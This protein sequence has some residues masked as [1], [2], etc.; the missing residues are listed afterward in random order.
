MMAGS[1][2]SFTHWSLEKVI[3]KI[4]QSNEQ[5]KINMFKADGHKESLIFAFF[6][7]FNLSVRQLSGVS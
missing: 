7:S 3:P 6:C 4:S 2:M 5:Q 1:K